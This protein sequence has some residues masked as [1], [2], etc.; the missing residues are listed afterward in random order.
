MKTFQIYLKSEKI[1]SVPA[2]RK[3]QNIYIYLKGDERRENEE[4]RVHQ[5]AIDFDTK[6][7]EAY[8]LFKVTNEALWSDCWPDSGR[9]SEAMPSGLLP[10]FASLCFHF[11]H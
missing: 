9:G 6:I 7:L 3:R 2:E 10:D 1:L 5:N 4:K 11:L 8:T